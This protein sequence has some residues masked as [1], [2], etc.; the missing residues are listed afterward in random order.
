MTRQKSKDGV[1]LVGYIRNTG[2]DLD[3]NVSKKI[4]LTCNLCG[5]ESC[6]HINELTR[7]EKT[8]IAKTAFPS[9]GRKSEELAVKFAL[10]AAC[11]AITMGGVG[12]ALLVWDF[13][14]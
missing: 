9:W 7:M 1:D 10:P 14:T 5:I 4:Q 3:V 8:I 6:R 13:L 11:I 2:E 12:I